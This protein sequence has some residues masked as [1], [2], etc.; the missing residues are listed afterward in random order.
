[1]Q[2]IVCFVVYNAI[3]YS[4]TVQRLQEDKTDENRLHGDDYED[5]YLKPKTATL[6]INWWSYP[7]RTALIVLC[8]IVEP[9]A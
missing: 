8:L 1:M 4:A 5:G 2:T 3:D 9:R 7:V 6:N